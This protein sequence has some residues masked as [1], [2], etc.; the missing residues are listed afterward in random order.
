MKRFI[1]GQ[2]LVWALLMIVNLILVPMTAMAADDDPGNG[3]QIAMRSTESEAPSGKKFTLELDYSLSSTTEQYTNAQIAVPLPKALTFDSAVN[4]ADTTYSYDAASHT[5]T[6]K[7]NSAVKAGTTG[8][9]Q[10][11]VYF[12]NYVTPNGTIANVQAQFDSNLGSKKSNIVQVTA[13]A[14]ADWEFKKERTRP[15][16]SLSP[17]AGSEVEYKI[18]FYDKNPSTYGRLELRNVV[19]QDTLPA[20]AQYVSSQP[21][22]VVAGNT[23]TWNQGTF[24]EGITYKEYIVKVKYPDTISGDITNIAEVSFNPLNQDKVTLKAE[25]KD[26]FTNESGYGSSGFFKMINDRQKEASPGQ[27]VSFNIVNMYNTANVSLKDY[28]FTDMTPEGLILQQITTP[29]FN[30]ISTYSVEYTLADNANGP[31]STWGTVRADQ[32]VTLTTSDPPIAGA[33]V[34]GVRFNFGEVPVDFYQTGSFEIR[35]QV[36]PGYLA[37]TEPSDSKRIT[38]IASLKYSFEGSLKEEQRSAFLYVVQGRPLIEVTKKVMNGASFSPG[39]TV[40]YRVSVRNTEFSSSDLNHPIIEDLL[41]SQLE[42]V[43]GS[44]VLINDSGLGI[45]SP[46]LEQSVDSATGRTLLKWSWKEDTPAVLGYDKKI[47][48]EFDVRIKAG[49]NAG[50][51]DNEVDV[52]SDHHAYLNHIDFAKKKKVNGKWYVYNNGAFYVNSVVKLESIKWVQGDLDGNNWTKYPDK[53][54]T[55]PGGKVE[56]KLQITNV[57]NIPVRSLLIIDSLPR[58]GD[59]GVVDTSPRDSKWSPVLTSEVSG[60]SYTKVSYTTDT[61]ISMA[62]GHWSTEPPADLTKVTGIKFELSDDHVITPGAQ[63]ELKWTMRAP[64]HA[65]TND[66]AA[67][68]SFGFTAKRGDNGKTLL[69]SEPLKVGVVVKEDAKGE[70]GDYV[71]LD[72][73]E[74]GIQN[75]PKEQGVNGVQVELYDAFGK[76]VQQ[77]ITSN[78]HNGS[79]GYYLFTNLDSGNYT[80][81]FN[82]PN[83]YSGWVKPNAGNNEATDSDPNSDGWTRVIR[84]AAG[85]KNHSID[86]GLLPPK[87]RIGDKVWIDA[88]GDGLQDNGE[89][90]IDG[91]PVHLYDKNGYLLD[92]TVTAR[93]GLYEFNHLTSGDYRV[94]FVLPKGLAFTKKGDGTKRDIDS[95]ADASGRSDLISL[96]PDEVNLT[97]D[98]GL[99]EPNSSIGNRVWLDVNK[100]GLQDAGEPGINGAAVQ[101][102]NES[103]QL[104]AKA[105]TV[106]DAVYGD[107]YYQFEQLWAGNYIVQFALPDSSYEFTVQGTDPKS[108]TD[109]NANPG[110]D[111]KTSLIPLGYGESNPTIDAG[112]VKVAQPPARGSIGDTVWLDANGDGIQNDGNTGVNGVVVKLF[113]NTGILQAST[114]TASVYDSVY[115]SVY[116][117]S[118]YYRF[119]NL[120]SGT[121]AVKFEL[122]EG[123]AFTTKGAGND[124]AV[125]SDASP[126][127]M[128]DWIALAPGQINLTVDAGLRR[129]TNPPAAG[130]IGDYVWIDENEDGIQN[131]K[132]VGLSGVTVKLYNNRDELLGTTVTGA[133]YGKTGYYLF[134]DLPSGSYKIK[135]DPP[136][137]YEFTYKG[138]GDNRAA[139]S[140]AGTD[141]Y[142]DLFH[143]AQGEHIRTIDAGLKKQAV[144]PPQSGKIG[145]WV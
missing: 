116:A 70:I 40:K 58:V 140:D 21:A 78:D 90:G 112:L 26:T 4:A 143:L 6:F 49:T 50:Y 134:D 130:S 5:V 96:G 38:N 43:P 121:Y 99:L 17:K 52:S 111:G 106:K 63:E 93:N 86:A 139:D 72:S 11:N 125:D 113:D 109:S 145:D 18:T 10:M 107:G 115:R 46:Q 132:E 100:N 59:T 141:G 89:A 7:F 131:D 3:I 64:V 118:G 16:P 75:E 24:G 137:G 119:D 135:F 33:V 104:L 65:P 48:L 36:N 123:Y 92:T 94:E 28:V 98:A 54:L 110:N 9:L 76:L 60:N 122:P 45:A 30:G 124:K 144:T 12:P 51:I 29:R 13:K 77:T 47:E 85:E 68:S 74:D 82:L 8:T 79:P 117:A 41:P 56:Y 23:V 22:A 138:A 25:R 62:G 53:G 88:N 120:L 31:W 71:W 44:T 136:A 83:G 42:Y 66:Q 15:I 67:W 80:V 32:S 27:S 81:K 39:D 108:D 133:V 142:T 73:N 95:D 102:L 35:Y 2:A 127:G 34:K 97:V 105:T 91:V 57:G 1:R 19:I 84:L 37:P 103:G 129:D 14:S 55:T 114:V 128:T 101:L 126:D 61:S 69:A 20:G 87:G